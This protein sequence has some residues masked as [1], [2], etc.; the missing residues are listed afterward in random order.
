[1]SERAAD[2]RGLA[3]A[4]QHGMTELQCA[5]VLLR[6]AHVVA[7]ADG[8]RTYI[9]FLDIAATLIVREIARVTFEEAT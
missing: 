5:L 8:R 6:E 1:V 4:E 3:V 2:I 7:I 9:A